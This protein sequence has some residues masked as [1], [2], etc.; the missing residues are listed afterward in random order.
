MYEIVYPHLQNPQVKDLSTPDVIVCGDRAL[1]EVKL[2]H[3]VEALIQTYRYP[4]KERKRHQYKT[5][6]RSS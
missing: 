2:S 5:P 6:T 3:K 4:Y 1:E